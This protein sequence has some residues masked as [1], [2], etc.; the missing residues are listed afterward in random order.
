L[1]IKRSQIPFVGFRK[2]N[3]QRFFT[4]LVI[5]LFIAVTGVEVSRTWNFHGM[6]F[7]YLAFLSGGT[8]ADK[9]GY[10]SVY[11]LDLVKQTQINLNESLGITADRGGSDP[12][13]MPVAL[14]PVFVAPF[15]LLSRLT[16]RFG[17]TLWTIL[18]LLIGAGYLVFFLRKMSK[19]WENSWREW[20]LLG[21]LLVAIPTV[22]NFTNGQ[23][24]VFLMIGAGEF[25]RCARNKKPVTAGL[26]LGLLLL[27]PQ[28][29]LLVIPALILL[30]NW[31]TFAGFCGSALVIL[32]TSVWLAGMDGMVAMVNMWGKFAPGIASSAPELMMN[33]RTAAL[34]V[35]DALGTWAGWIL[36][37]L[38]I[39]GTL[40]LFIR[41]LRAKPEFGTPRWAMAMLGVFLASCSVTWHAHAHMAMALFPFLIF[42]LSS[43]LL[44]Q[45]RVTAWVTIPQALYLASLLLVGLELAGVMPDLFIHGRVMGLAVLGVNLGLLVYI[46]SFQKAG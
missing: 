39:L 36:A 27:K 22:S 31:K 32:G 20:G 45:E 19:T 7:D 35:N 12:N 37:G 18:N 46:T 33:W 5:L 1:E 21:L 40:F 24:E 28:V 10:A 11:D 29:L 26:Y 4:I 15:Q 38:G 25:I 23:V 41:I 13:P 3:W 14:L 34:L 2:Q 9:Q 42:G 16:P 6:G 8:I 30:G 44:T 43:G 17:F